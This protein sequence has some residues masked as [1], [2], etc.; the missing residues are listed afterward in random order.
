MLTSAKIYENCTYTFKFKDGESSIRLL[1]ES[2]NKVLFFAGPKHDDR[3]IVVNDCIEGKW[4]DEVRL[5]APP[6]GEPGHGRLSIKFAANRL[7]VWTEAFAT[8]FARFDLA[9]ARRVRFLKTFRADDVHGALESR[10]LSPE[11]MGFEL[12]HHLLHARIALLER[13]L[14]ARSISPTDM[15]AE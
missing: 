8:Q 13:A 14:Q 1:D 7:E 12:N 6:P 9:R 4:G 5:G 10:V 2:G 3:T 15:A 11:A